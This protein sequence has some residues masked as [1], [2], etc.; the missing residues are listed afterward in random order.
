M[1]LVGIQGL[2]GRIPSTARPMF[3]YKMHLG[4]RLCTCGLRQG[5][6]CPCTHVVNFCHKT[7]RGITP[8]INRYDTRDCWTSQYSGLATYP[9]PSTS[10]LEF[11][12]D[13]SILLP[14]E[15]RPGRS[16]P[17]V[18]RRRGAWEASRVRVSR[19][20]LCRARNRN[21]RT[22]PNSAGAVATQQ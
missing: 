2:Q 15:L 18:H 11:E 12:M 8:F 16:R 10:D 7:G 3:F 22:C 19:C 5:A 1:Q 20:G 9:V 14:L 4:G 13:D 17:R 21:R 6:Q